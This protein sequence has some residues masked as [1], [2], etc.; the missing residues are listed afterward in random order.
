MNRTR[1]GVLYVTAVVIVAAP[2]VL[3]FVMHLSATPSEAVIVP[4][5]YARGATSV[6]AGSASAATSSTGSLVALA[7]RDPLALARIGHERYEREIDDYRCVLIKQESI[8][9]TLT[10]VE[11]VELRFRKA[12]H[13]VY[14]LWRKNA[15]QAKRALFKEDDPDFI[16]D[17]GQPIAR[18]EP[19]GAVV[20]IFVKDIMIP[21]NGEQARKVSRRTID[22]CGFGATFDLLQRF[23]GIARQKGVLDVRYAGIAEVDGRP[24]YVIVRHLPY[25]GEGG[26]YPDAKMVLHLDREWLLPVAVESF[27]DADGTK[28]LGRYFFTQVEVNPGLTDQ[29]FEF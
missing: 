20:R 15:S 16:N 4:V 11:E 28:L 6:V 5:S 19:A 2:P 26:A 22:E 24:T 13:T 21:V 25:E 1:R 27:A 23:N 9:G 29:D 10:A 7:E 17:E 14:M 18:V 8:C 3:W 12:P